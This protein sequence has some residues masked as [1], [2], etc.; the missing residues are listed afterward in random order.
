MPD[1]LGDGQAWKCVLFS[2]KFPKPINCWIFRRINSRVP[3][4]IIEIVAEQELVSPYDL[5]D[6]DY[7]KI[8]L[9]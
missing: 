4:G 3:R 5:K 7:V 9:I 2:G 8:E 1:Y 6:G